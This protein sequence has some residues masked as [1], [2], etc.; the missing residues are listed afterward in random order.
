MLEKIKTFDFPGTTKCPG[1]VHKDVWESRWG[2][3]VRNLAP[4]GGDDTDF[5]KKLWENE[6]KDF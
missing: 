6:C 3:G 4:T 1:L 5:A 2:D